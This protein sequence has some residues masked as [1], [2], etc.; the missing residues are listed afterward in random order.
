M[1]SLWKTV[2]YEEARRLLE[3]SILPRVLDAVRTEIIEEWRG[4][5]P[6]DSAARETLHAEDRGLDRIKAY[7]QG[8]IGDMEAAS[9]LSEQ[10]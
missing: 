8:M 5:G 3:R 9:V 6:D 10:D 1:D 2:D 7:L 4:T